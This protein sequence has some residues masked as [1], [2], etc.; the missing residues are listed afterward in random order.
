MPA[1]PCLGPGKG[2]CPNNML[3]RDGSRCDDCEREN[4][5]RRRDEGLTGHV[6]RHVPERIKLRT[7]RDQGHRCGRCQVHEDVLHAMAPP[8]YLEIHHRDGNPNNNR[9]G[10]HVAY[11]PDCHHIVE[12]GDA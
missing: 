5:G 6:G 9:P 12:R 4:T 1:R 2:S 3:V 8:Q 10:N 11:C 7:I